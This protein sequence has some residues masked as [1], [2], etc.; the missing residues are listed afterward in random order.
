M[1]KKGVDKRHSKTAI[2]TALYKAIANLEFTNERLGPDYLAKNFLPPHWKFFIKFEKI[3][4]RSKRKFNKLVP[5]M[6]EYVL[7]RTVFF[8]RIF[9]DA[10]QDRIPQIVLLGA[11]YDTR[12]YRFAGLNNK[13]EIFELDIATTQYRK[14]NC[15]K[16]AQID[17][18]EHV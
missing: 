9:V 13:S 14:K 11:G 16:K 12:A 1:S 17:I 4:A 18:P 7:A 15:L 3:R 2:I 5:G 10:L 6:Y 8:D